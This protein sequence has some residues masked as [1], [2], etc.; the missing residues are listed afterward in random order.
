LTK[1]EEKKTSKKF[2]EYINKNR[3]GDCAEE[4]FKK[5][6]TPWQ[7]QVAIELFVNERDH[8][9]ME[10]KLKRNERILWAVFGIVAL[11]ALSNFVSTYIL[12]LLG[13]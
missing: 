12:P 8:K 1:E 4:V 7:K 9:L 5:A 3:D 6:K 11:T 10:E 13:V 2:L